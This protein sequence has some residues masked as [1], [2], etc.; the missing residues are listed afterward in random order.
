MSLKRRENA[1]DPNNNTD[2]KGYRL[3]SNTPVYYGKKE[4][5]FFERLLEKENVTSQKNL[6][7]I[8]LMALKQ[9]DSFDEYFNKFQQLA[10]EVDMREEDLILLF[11]NGLRSK[12]RF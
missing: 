11:T 7:K 6:T 3:D 5:N 2:G 9:V 12:A 10:N 1:N 8:K 4:E